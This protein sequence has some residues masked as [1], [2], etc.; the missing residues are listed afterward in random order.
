MERMGGEETMDWERG[1]FCFFVEGRG[2]I[3]SETSSVIIE[4]Y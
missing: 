3:M 2:M 4:F 1:G